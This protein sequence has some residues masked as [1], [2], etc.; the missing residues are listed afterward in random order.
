VDLFDVRLRLQRERDPQ[1]HAPRW[2]LARTS[3][4]GMARSGSRS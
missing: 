2:S 3:S 1:G 4:Q